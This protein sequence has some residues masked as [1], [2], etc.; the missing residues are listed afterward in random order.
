MINLLRHSHA[1]HGSHSRQQRSSGFEWS[2][3]MLFHPSILLL[4]AS[5]LKMSSW[6][7]MAVG[8]NGESTFQAARRNMDKRASHFPFNEDSLVSY[9][10]TSSLQLAQNLVTCLHWATRSLGKIL[11]FFVFFFW[12]KKGF[13]GRQ[14]SPCHKNV[15][16]SPPFPSIPPS[17]PKL[18]PS[19]QR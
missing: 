17:Q 9:T 4:V 15:L 18:I 12:L 13:E 16:L 5:T 1:A 3:L 2:R 6:S 11:V 10:T 7:K 8:A 14:L 19:L